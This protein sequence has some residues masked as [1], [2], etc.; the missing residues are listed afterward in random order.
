DV[1][2]SDMFGLLTAFVAGGFDVTATPPLR[3]RLFRLSETEHVFAIVMHHIA[4]DGFSMG[5]LARDLVLAYEARST[6]KDF[7]REPLEVQYADYALWQR[8]VLGSDDD[9]DSLLSRQL[10]YWT[11]TLDGI[12]DVLPLPTDHPRPAVASYRG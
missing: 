7:A 4:A 8:R 3:A 12:P 11:G 6:G 10:S 2:E 9:P 1:S 5:P